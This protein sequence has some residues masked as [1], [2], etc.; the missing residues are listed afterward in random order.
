MKNK[1]IFLTFAIA[2][3]STAC[4][5]SIPS[6]TNE[7]IDKSLLATIVASTLQALT[8]NPTELPVEI[9]PAS[10]AP[11]PVVLPHSLYF[12]SGR[13]GNNQI[14]RM[15]KD[16]FSIEQ[17]TFE[18][19]DV[20][21]F[22]VDSN[23]G[24][25][26]YITSNRLVYHPNS[27]DSPNIL[28]DMPESNQDSD[29]YFYRNLLSKPRFSP[30]GKILAFALNGI[31]LYDLETDQ[32][33]HVIENELET[34]ESGNI[35]PRKLYFPDTWSPD[36]NKLL[37]SIGYLEAGTLAFLDIQSSALTELNSTGIVCCQAIWDRN[38][39][40]IFVASPYLGLVDT[41]LWQY[42]A[43][44]GAEIVLL[45]TSNDDAT[46]NYVGWPVESLDNDLF[47]FYSNTAGIPDGD[48]ALRLVR[49]PKN[50]LED[51]EALREDSLLIREALW[52]PDAS[53]VLIV[54]S[55]QA[56]NTT[57]VLVRL[58]ASPLEVLT[59]DALHLRWGP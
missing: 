29:D 44:S 50:E 18:N 46:I 33:N 13:S 56:A 23:N 15:E 38:S 47:Y 3:I 11:I 14:W 19:E 28:L 43:A 51:R 49:S 37:L 31:Q 4:T 40:S 8:I 54:Q 16:A 52:A 57:L 53:L 21:D 55:I 30:D 20:I 22:D 27:H 26:A 58:D 36:G 9:P 10:P 6:P 34:L 24:A 2:L 12:L 5:P 25:L 7:A 41:G 59:N 1:S 32:I 35:I 39:E 42:D 45:P 48:V 17:I